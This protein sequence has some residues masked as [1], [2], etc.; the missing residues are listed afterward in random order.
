MSPTEALP[1]DP[2]PA[3][4]VMDKP[5]DV[6]DA[7]SR[8]EKWAEQVFASEGRIAPDIEQTPDGTEDFLEQLERDGEASEDEEFEEDS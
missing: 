4:V 6:Q 7:L 2:T 1:T 3:T 8:T 5:A